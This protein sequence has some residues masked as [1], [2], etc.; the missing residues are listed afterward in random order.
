MLI[1]LAISLHIGNVTA[2]WTWAY[3]Y[4]I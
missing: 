1:N 4:I 3:R 2:K